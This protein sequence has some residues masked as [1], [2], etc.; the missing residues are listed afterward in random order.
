MDG[1]ER[2]G[3]LRKENAKEGKGEENRE[4]NRGGKVNFVAFDNR[5][6]EC[7]QNRFYRIHWTQIKCMS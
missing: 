1:M 5:P 2:F 7:F 4:S 6:I 3:N